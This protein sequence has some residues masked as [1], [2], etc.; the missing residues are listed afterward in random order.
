MAGVMSNI[1]SVFLPRQLGDSRRYFFKSSAARFLD[2][3]IFAAKVRAS[4]SSSTAFVENKPPTVAI[5]FC[6]S[7]WL[8]HCQ[9]LEI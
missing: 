4:S 9:I 7:L 3:R 2:K 8:F 1:S 6:F 5:A